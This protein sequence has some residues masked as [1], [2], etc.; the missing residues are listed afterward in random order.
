MV[1]NI[2]DYIRNKHFDELSGYP[3]YLRQAMLFKYMTEA[4]PLSIR[5]GDRI[6][7]WYGFES[8]EDVA[9]DEKKRFAYNRI[10]SDSQARLRSHMH[11]DLKISVAF[12]SAHTCI[13]YETVVEK[14][15]S[16]YVSLVEAE[17]KKSLDN[18]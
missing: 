11:N 4:M 3:A 2:C 17:L 8:S 5:D 6:A 13:D 1:Y 14:G 18:E 7:G 12:N 10:L 15:I 16:Y 9:V